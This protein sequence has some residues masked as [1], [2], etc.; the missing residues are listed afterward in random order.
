[1]G[2]V[3]PEVVLKKEA[4]DEYDDNH[5]INAHDYVNIPEPKQEFKIK[6][7]PSDQINETLTLE[8]S[9]NMKY[10]EFNHNGLTGTLIEE[11]EQRDNLESE[12]NGINRTD[13]YSFSIPIGRF[14][15]SMDRISE[16]MFK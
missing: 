6:F 7:E 4:H 16:E 1:M 13:A 11:N 15:E 10:E 9:L 14:D 8:N 2:G 3:T 5:L 12:Q